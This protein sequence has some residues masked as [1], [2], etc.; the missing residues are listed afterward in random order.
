MSC[1]DQRI[2]WNAMYTNYRHG[3]V[4]NFHT[5]YVWENLVL[6]GPADLVA[7]AEALDFT[8]QPNMYQNTNLCHTRNNA[9]TIFQDDL[10]IPG[11]SYSLGS[12]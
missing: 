4:L 7:C 12:R 6:G 5:P 3:K 9:S 1:F 2:P 8:S 11:I 10:K